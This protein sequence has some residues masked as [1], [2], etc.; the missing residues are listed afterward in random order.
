MRAVAMVIFLGIASLFLSPAEPI[1]TRP[2]KESDCCG[3]VGRAIDLVD[4]MKA[5][6]TRRQVEEHFV[7]DGGMQFPENTR[8]GY[9]GCPEIKIDVD[10]KV[11]DS[12]DGRSGPDDVVVKVSRPY[13]EE[14]SK[15]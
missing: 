7:K 4:A 12:K 10:F 5:G 11:V 1:G 6:T 2:D 14:P 3:V 9:L 13:L 8:Y 15:N